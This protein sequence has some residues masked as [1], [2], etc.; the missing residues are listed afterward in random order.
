MLEIKDLHQSYF[1]GTNALNGISFVLNDGEK[2]A[3]LSK[4]AVMLRST[5]FIALQ[6]Y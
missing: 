6:F 4:N 1:Y 2:L 3:V 5:S